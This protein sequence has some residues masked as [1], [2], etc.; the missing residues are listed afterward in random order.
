MGGRRIV[1]SLV[2]GVLDILFPAQCVACN[3]AGAYICMQCEKFLG[4]APLICPVCLQSTYTGERHEQCYKKYGLDGL[5]SIWENEGSIKELLHKTKYQGITHIL[6]ELANKAFVVMAADTQRFG[7]F[8]NLLILE[9]TVFTYV[10]MHKKKEKQRG[11]NQAE[12][13]AK[14][15]ARILKNSVVPLLVKSTETQA[16]MKL[17]KQERLYNVKDVFSIVS[18][19]DSTQIER[20]ILVDD[21]WTT[22]ATMKECCKVL[23]EAGVKQVWGFT[24]ARTV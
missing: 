9:N 3:K 24:L 19:I 7:I 11:F 20:V 8:L 13:F 6:Q 5:V 10:P 17:T 12:L 16:Q 21:I 18:T 2:N 1:K 4:E 14:E 23:K 22:G 15:M